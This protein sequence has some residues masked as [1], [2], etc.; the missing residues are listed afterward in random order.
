M[1]IDAK[2]VKDSNGN[3]Y[4]LG[5]KNTQIQFGFKDTYSDRQ[6]SGDS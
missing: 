4:L 6:G 1:R 5:K 2:V 3:R